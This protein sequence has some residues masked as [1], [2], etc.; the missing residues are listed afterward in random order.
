MQQGGKVEEDADVM[1]VV[2]EFVVRSACPERQGD[3]D[4]QEQPR[5]LSHNNRKVVKVDLGRKIRIHA[6]SYVVA[7][8]RKG[9]PEQCQVLY[10]Q[11]IEKRDLFFVVCRLDTSKENY[12]SS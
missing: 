9:I 11:K 4:S 10:T 5:C 2:E 7:K 8:A 3:H 1:C 12:T 6:I